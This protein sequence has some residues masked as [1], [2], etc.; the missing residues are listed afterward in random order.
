M[1]LKVGKSV[2]SPFQIKCAPEE[3]PRARGSDTPP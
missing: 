3:R 2:F 1:N